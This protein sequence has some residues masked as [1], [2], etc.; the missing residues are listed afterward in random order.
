MHGKRDIASYT[1]FYD[2]KLVGR[3]NFF[4]K[5]IYHHISFERSFIAD[6]FLLKDHDLQ[7]MQKR[8]I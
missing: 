7:I 8:N 3:E 2:V 5:H 6:H 4:F 1:K